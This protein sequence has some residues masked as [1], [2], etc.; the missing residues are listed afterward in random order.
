MSK[1]VLPICLVFCACKSKAEP[2]KATPAIDKPAE[3]KPATPATPPVAAK[4]RAKAGEYSTTSIA[5]PGGTA[6]GVGMDYLL[7]DPRTKSVWV[8]AGNTGSVDVIDAATG[9]LTRLEGFAT[10]EM[11][12]RGKK[13]LVGPSS[14]TLG[15]GVV[16]IGSRGDSSICAVDDVKLV[17]GTCGKLDS[18]P[19]GIAYVA[20][21]KE[22][23]VT[24]PR[25][26]SIRILDA[27]T[28]AQKAKLTFE[29]DPEGFAV[30][31]VRGR[32]YTNLEDK[33]Q[34]LSIDL[35]SHKTVATW[36]PSCGEDGPHGLRLAEPEGFLLVACSTKVETL[37]VGHD[38]ATLGSIDTGDGVDDLDY[39]PASHLVY[40][41]AAKAATLTIAA[42]DAKGALTLRASVPT[43]D[44]ARNGVADADGVVY[45]AHGKGSELIVAT[46]PKP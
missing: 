37:D 26:K 46:P 39:M 17:K 22:V 1:L 42:L 4:P 3:T 27:T 13:R 31:N 41:G 14:A 10:Q 35:A 24:T 19:D 9:K 36:K 32:F 12:R 21:T 33:D 44:G 29:G 8:P 38:G 11:E 34:T 23:W 40:V 6:D 15:D 7:F 25:D 5:L 30:D 28:L 45:L 20:K 18:M 16:Y 2:E 43:K